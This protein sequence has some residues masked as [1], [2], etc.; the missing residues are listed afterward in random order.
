M[1]R[2]TNPDAVR[3]LFGAAAADEV[4]GKVELAQA[5]V[6]ADGRPEHLPGVLRDAVVREHQCLQMRRQLR[7]RHPHGTEQMLAP[8]W[9]SLTLSAD[10]HTSYENTRLEP[11]A[12]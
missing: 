6:L 3:E 4:P 12:L 2:R 7:A 1:G 5:G 11:S 8:H 9:N 10:T